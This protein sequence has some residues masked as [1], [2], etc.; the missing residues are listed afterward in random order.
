[1][2]NPIRRIAEDP[3][4]AAERFARSPLVPGIAIAGVVDGVV[5]VAAGGEATLDTAFRPGS[6]TKLLTATLVAQCAEDGLLTLDDPLSSYVPGFDER[7]KIRHLITHSSGID[8][9]DVFV[10]TGDDDDALDR[11]I[12]LLQGAG[13]LFDPG[14]TFS[15]CNGGFALAGHVVALVRGAT[16]EEVMR[17]HLFEPLGMTDSRFEPTD[18]AFQSGQFLSGGMTRAL[19]PAGGTLVSTATDLGRFLADHLARPERSWMRRLAA[20]APGGVA[21]MQ[22]AGAGWMVWHGSSRVGGANPGHSGYLAIDPEATCAIATLTNGEQGVNA[23][24]TELD[25]AAPAP[26][27][28]GPAPTDLHQFEG[29]Y[30]SHIMQVTL[31]V[32]DGTLTAEMNGTFAPLVPQDA[33][34]FSS[35]LG[36]IALF[37]RLARWRMRCLRK[38]S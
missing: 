11:Y 34:S 14:A 15:Y 29:E 24:A 32:V 25:A 23:V 22:G 17:H 36:P 1:M 4:A 33:H 5:N 28:Q 26:P 27:D 31:R 6:I 35:M 12:E 16:W 38:T 9:G 20:P 37:D 8:A 7:I 10:D 18:A 19:G 13:Q 2:T 3:A 21:L 30:A